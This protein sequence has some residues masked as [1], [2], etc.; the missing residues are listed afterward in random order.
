MKLIDLYYNEAD[1]NIADAFEYLDVDELETLKSELE[2]GEYDAIYDLTDEI[3]ETTMPIDKYSLIDL[4]KDR[5]DFMTSETGFRGSAIDN[6][7]LNVYSDLEEYV[8]NHIL[9]KLQDLLDI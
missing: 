5:P 3:V 1:M 4:A 9:D 7:S 8:L 6:I 2:S